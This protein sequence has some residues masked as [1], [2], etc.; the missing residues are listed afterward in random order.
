MSTPPK[1]V[2]NHSNQQ[3]IWHDAAA[4]VQDTI[5]PVITVHVNSFKLVSKALHLDAVVDNAKALYHTAQNLIYCDAKKQICGDITANRVEQSRNPLLS[6]KELAV[7]LGAV[8]LLAGIALSGS[9][10]KNY[11]EM[12]Q[13]LAVV[14]TTAVIGGLVADK[15]RVSV[16]PFPYDRSNSEAN[17]LGFGV[18]VGVGAYGPMITFS[19]GGEPEPKPLS[20]EEWE[21]IMDEINK[22]QFKG[23]IFG[24]KKQSAFPKPVAL[25]KPLEFPT[26]PQLGISGDYFEY[27]SPYNKPLSLGIIFENPILNTEPRPT[28]Y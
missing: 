15:V 4:W 10:N 8:A 13:D 23:T 6:D 11:R 22:S 25:P 17:D 12:G 28:S 26:V 1:S 20:N 14:G 24:S 19:F 16:A 9:E 27:N 5:E 3:S 7:G 2:N 21:K 18:D